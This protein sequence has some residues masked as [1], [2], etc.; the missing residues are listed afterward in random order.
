MLLTL[1]YSWFD[2]SGIVR[3]NARNRVKERAQ[4]AASSGGALACN[5]SVPQPVATFSSWG[6]S[7]ILMIFQWAQTT[8]YELT[9]IKNCDDCDRCKSIDVAGI[10]K[11]TANDRIDWNTG[12]GG[13]HGWVYP[14]AFVSD[15]LVNACSFGTDYPINAKSN[16]S[17]NWTFAC[18]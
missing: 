15:Q 16:D 2:P 14:P 10:W 1:D 7:P 3:L 5:E 13:G 9:V 18:P 17:G 8:E 6:L 12:M 11:N 4:S